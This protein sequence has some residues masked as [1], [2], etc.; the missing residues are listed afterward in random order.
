MLGWHTRGYL[1]HV[2]Y[3]HL[4]QS[5]TFRLADA[6]PRGVVAS[7]QRELASRPAEERP[8]LLRA[9]SDA[10]EDAGAGSCVLRRDD[11][12]RA[13]ADQLRRGD[14]VGY[15]IA[16]WVVMPN[17]VHVLVGPVGTGRVEL[18]RATRAWKGASARAINLQLGRTGALWQRESFD[19]WIRDDAH[20][21]T[22]AAYIAQNPVKAGLCRRAEDWRW[23]HAS[24]VG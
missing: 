12:A 24:R 6:L 15:H 1:P 3:P 20:F 2:D 19:R 9:R 7:W 11:C 16:A 18:T 17:H 21:R 5:V 8:R 14:G 13:V 22:V 4:W 10:Y 23:S